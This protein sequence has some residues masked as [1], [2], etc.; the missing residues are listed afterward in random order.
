[1]F[2]QGIQ[3]R[4][5][6]KILW[7]QLFVHSF[8]TQSTLLYL[9]VN[10][11]DMNGTYHSFHLSLTEQI[12]HIALSFHTAHALLQAHLRIQGSQGGNH[13]NIDI[14]FLFKCTFLVCNYPVKPSNKILGIWT[15]KEI[16]ERKG[17]D[18][19]TRQRRRQWREGELCYKISEVLGLWNFTDGPVVK[20]TCLAM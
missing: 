13:Y 4:Y 6:G 1:M 2:S 9:N 20:N 19:R 5:M 7:N 16:E 3:I 18:A 14:A 10:Y 11:T 8:N 17:K 12:A 15:Q